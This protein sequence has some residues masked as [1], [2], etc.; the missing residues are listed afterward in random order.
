MSYSGDVCFP[1]EHSDDVRKKC[2]N[3]VF[4]INMP[5]EFQLD[6]VP[7]EYA[8]MFSGLFATSDARY[9]CYGL[10]VAPTTL[11]RHFQGVVCFKNER[12]KVAVAKLINE[13]FGRWPYVACMRGTVQ[14]A[15]DYCK[16][17]GQFDEL[18]EQP[19]S[20]EGKGE[21]AAEQAREIIKLAKE[22]KL[23]EIADMYPAKFL[24][25]YNSL[26]RISA[27][28]P[29]KYKNLAQCCGIYIHGP[30]GVGKSH[31]VRA[32]GHKYYD[33]LL[34]K[35]WDGYQNDAIVL[36]EEVDPVNTQFLSFHLK[37]WLDRYP[38]AVEIKNSTRTVRPEFFIITSQYTIREIATD[39]KD[40]FN[41]PLYDALSRRCVTIEIPD[42]PSRE[43]AAKK[44]R[45]VMVNMRQAN[46]DY[47]G[48]LEGEPLVLPTVPSRAVRSRSPSPRSSPVAS[49]LRSP[50]R[51]QFSLLSVPVAPR[52][53]VYNI[54]CSPSKFSIDSWR[55][56]QEP[57]MISH[58][59]ASQDEFPMIDLENDVI[60][61]TDE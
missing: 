59:S 45:E 15:V 11:R 6:A 61:L 32:L 55:D 4:T 39:P 8:L 41:G 58:V 1:S 50:P 30:A 21:K 29:Q 27:S 5:V 42:I 54:E 2:R 43:A 25:N 37:R 22:G 24:Q 40:G 12:S 20:K 17:D 49:P 56:E 34:Q 47:D 48:E 9:L 60:D 19:M 46:L 26:Q 53:L 51:S 18:G 3:F 31:L 44:L 7:M 57:D 16:K 10:E 14:Q 13:V 35:W 38:V 23:D 33:K 28:A 36:L 52:K